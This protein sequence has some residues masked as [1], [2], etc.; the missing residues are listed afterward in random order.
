MKAAN[1]EWLRW[2]CHDNQVLV[3]EEFGVL[4]SSKP[5]IFIKAV[6]WSGFSS[7]SLSLYMSSEMVFS[8]IVIFASMPNTSA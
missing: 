1:A 7:I 6:D 4:I 3:G 8:R 2:R 5:A